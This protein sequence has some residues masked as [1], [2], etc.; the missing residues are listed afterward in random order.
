MVIRR[1]VFRRMAVSACFL[2]VL[3]GWSPHTI[4]GDVATPSV[5]YNVDANRAFDPYL[6]SVEEQVD[7]R[8]GTLV[9]RQTDLV[10]SGRNG[11]DLEFVR[12]YAANLSTLGYEHADLDYNTI[13]TSNYVT[14]NR[15][16]ENWVTAPYAISKGW[17]LGFPKLEFHQNSIGETAY[18]HLGNGTIYELNADLQLKGHPYKDKQVIYDIDAFS[19]TICNYEGSEGSLSSYYALVHADGRKDFFERSGLWLGARDRFGNEIKVH[20]CYNSHGQ[21]YLGGF[22]DSLGRRVTVT[23]AYDQMRG[24]SYGIRGITVGDRSIQY[25]VSPNDDPSGG[26]LDYVV[27]AQGRI[28]EY[29]YDDGQSMFCHAER[30]YFPYDCDSFSPLPAANNHTLLKSVK[31][32]NGGYTRYEYAKVRYE[33]GYGVLSPPFGY[34]YDMQ[35]FRETFRLTRRADEALQNGIARQFNVR[36]YSYGSPTTITHVKETWDTSSFGTLTETIS[37][38]PRGHLLYRKL[39]TGTI[40]QTYSY[41]YPPDT[42]SFPNQ[43]SWTVPESTTV[44]WRDTS[45]GAEVSYTT[46]HTW[47]IYLDLLT[48]TDTI[49]RDVRMSYDPNYHMLLERIEKVQLTPAQWKRSQ[50]KLDPSDNR[51]INEEVHYVGFWDGGSGWTPTSQTM[52][53]RYEYQPGFPGNVTK[54]KTVMG[55]VNGVEQ[56]H[57]VSYGHDTT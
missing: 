26:K 12:V 28:T 40:E 27:D 8:T 9:L 7:P 31:R 33:G 54:K 14:P 41:T 11:F 47:N 6:G 36:T 37:Y 35:Y 48:E 1:W 43:I 20:W 32:P 4:A 21:A 18:L 42:G 2:F 52:T 10:L 50:Y 55:V 19:T 49:G 25:S 15:S 29:S 56:L 57:E 53:V 5:R 51:R 44:K 13:K 17:S 30:S 45:S 23:T 38:S 39:Q 24:I 34:P 22:T 46:Y 16:Q 3:V